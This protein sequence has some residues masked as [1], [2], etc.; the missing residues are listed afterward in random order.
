MKALSLKQPFAE[1]V[2]SGRKTIELRK[3]R[4]NFR[5]EFLVHASKN[6]DMTAMERFGF[7]EDSLPLGFIVGKAKLIDVKDY[8]KNKE[9]FEKDSNKH[10]ASSEW[11]NFGF[12]LDNLT[13]LQKPISAKGALNFWNFDSYIKL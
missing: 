5:G 12:I 8:N 9:E 13:K 4:T 3:W 10:L 11:G 6:P 2:V 1:L 7:K